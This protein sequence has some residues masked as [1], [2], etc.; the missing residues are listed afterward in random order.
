M[1]I[2]APCIIAS[3]RCVQLYHLDAEECMYELMETVRSDSASLELPVSG[4]RFI[5]TAAN[6]HLL[7]ASCMLY[8]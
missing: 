5:L 8:H 1:F 7:I 2:G 3:A 4:I 6:K